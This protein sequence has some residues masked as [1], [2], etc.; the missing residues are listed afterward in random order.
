MSSVRTR[1]VVVLT[2]TLLAA[3]TALGWWSAR[4]TR[5]PQPESFASS[6]SAVVEPG[7]A[8][9]G[10]A[11]ENLRESASEAVAGAPLASAHTGPHGRV[12]LED[13]RGLAALDVLLV[14]EGVVEA[15]VRTLRD[16][17]FRLP[18]PRSLPAQV[19]VAPDPRMI[20]ADPVH[21]L[22]SAEA[23]GEVPLLFQATTADS[24]P[25]RG[26]LVDAR[27]NEP[28]PEFRFMCIDT[29][30]TDDGVTSDAEGRFETA[31]D[32][33]LGRIRLWLTEFPGSMGR[34]GPYDHV[35]ERL[36]EVSLIP[37]P[38]GPTYTLAFT[39]PA[40]RGVT[41][42]FAEVRGHQV[43]PRGYPALFQRSR[44]RAGERPWVRLHPYEVSEGPGPPWVLVIESDDG[45]WSGSVEVDGRVG[46]HPGA[47]PV[48]VVACASIH[49]RL[50]GAGEEGRPLV[51][52]VRVELADGRV[53]WAH[54]D[55]EG[56]F[57]VGGLPGGSA[58]LSVELEG[59]QTLE[60]VVELTVGAASRPVLRLAPVPIVGELTGA[61]RTSSGA[62]LPGLYLEVTAPGTPARYVP[63]DWVEGEDATE[64]RF[65]L[66]V[67][68]G[69][70][71]LRPMTELFGLAA[72]PASLT[73]HAPARGLDFHVS[74]RSDRATF[75]LSL[76][77]AHGERVEGARVWLRD[78]E[79]RRILEGPV[80]PGGT[81][82][83]DHPA[84]ARFTW[85]VVAPGTRIHTADERAF[86][87]V[88]GVRRAEVELRAG[89]G[90]WIALVDRETDEP[91][92]GVILSL[93]GT[94]TSPSDVRGFVRVEREAPPTSLSIVG[95]TWR[96]S[97]DNR[98]VDAN[99]GRFAAEAGGWSLG[100]YLERR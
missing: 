12:S 41:D 28:L 74:D 10:E 63:V 49:G 59:F 35:R 56:A 14:V 91:I 99:T 19:Q 2:T 11:L 92:E 67:P 60:Q 34:Y 6:D 95:E 18:A 71:T 45:L 87:P 64:G 4:S 75:E 68:A 52:P 32:Y 5:G 29:I 47:L 65:Q 93:D 43:S 33:G 94:R 38:V 61:V 80:P 88:G 82:L 23:H 3:L 69:D 25:F 40:G 9:G 66:P 90:A 44:L 81:L 1:G 39:P 24:S 27:T 20:L 22:T 16:G 85:S 53:L 31:Q 97:R 21:A 17:G 98:A 7:Y 37:V 55:R 70:W 79:G 83:V 26:V 30:G 84:G 89:W 76:T 15:R 13:G 77:D 46:R 36:D 48:E 96:L 54:S 58:A 57:V 86:E 72:Q 100:L 42:F 62:S 8:R 50:E 73:I 78:A 51:A